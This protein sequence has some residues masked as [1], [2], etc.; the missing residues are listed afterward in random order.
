MASVTSTNQQINTNITQKVSNVM[1][2]SSAASDVHKQWKCNTSLAVAS[3]EK[4]AAAASAAA[5]R[6]PAVCG[7]RQGHYCCSA[8]THTPAPNISRH[9][10][11]GNAERPLRPLPYFPSRCKKAL[12]GLLPFYCNSAL[13]FKTL[14]FQYKNMKCKGWDLFLVFPAAISCSRLMED[15]YYV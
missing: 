10:L 6:T 2:A 9:T 1:S 11:Y 4:A 13:D 8:P 3:L 7:R 5:A 15:H 12:S 14:V